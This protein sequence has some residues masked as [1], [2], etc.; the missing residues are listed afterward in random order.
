MKP[1]VGYVHELLRFTRLNVCVTMVT[2]PAV[3]VSEAAATTTMRVELLETT[4]PTLTPASSTFR[5]ELASPNKR[6]PLMVTSVPTWPDEG[7][8]LEMTPLAS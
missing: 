2:L 1:G 7:T 8:T 5:S 4:E 6:V 3:G